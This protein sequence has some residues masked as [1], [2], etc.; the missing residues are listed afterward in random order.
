[1]RNGKRTYRYSTDMRGGCYQCHGEQAH[2]YQNNAQALAARHHDATGHTTWVEVVHEIF[3]GPKL[4]DEEYGQINGA[5]L[6]AK[7]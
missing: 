5:T 4:T 3:Y 7:T 6:Q 1:M 2:W